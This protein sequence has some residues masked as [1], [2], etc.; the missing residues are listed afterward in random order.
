MPNS[1][2]VT[3]L[4]QSAVAGDSRA[5]DL[6]LP[7]VYEELRALAQSQ[8]GR[9]R[10]GHTLQATALVHEAYVHLVDQSRSN[11]R[12]R[13]HFIAVA[14]TAMRRILVD[15]ARGRGRVKRGGGMARVSLEAVA[16]IVAAKDVDIVGL[17]DALAKL[18]AVDERKSKLVELRFFGGAS[19]E[20][21]AD[22]VGVST[23]TAKREWQVARAFLYRE[24]TV[25][26]STND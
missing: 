26:D 11:F 25:E 24:M 18:A 21:A 16:G 8:L 15:H 5:A 22:I 7:A 19:I 12:D 9:E 1:H 23:A 10:A 13:Q 6:L 20:E 17:D 14:T 2:D 4:L 3:V